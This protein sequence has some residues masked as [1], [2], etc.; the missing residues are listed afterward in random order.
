MKGFEMPMAGSARPLGRFA[1]A[2]FWTVMLALLLGCSEAADP[3]DARFLRRQFPEQAD[4][5]LQG[6]LAFA[7]A[8]DGFE[9][10]QPLDVR[11]D[12]AGAGGLPFR[13]PRDGDGAVR[14]SLPDGSE[15]QVRELGATGAGEIEEGAVAYARA[16]GTS[17]WT[18]LEDGY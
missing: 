3:L 13:F 4:A 6:P 1:L 8:G 15:A 5:I 14:F 7:P 16:G 18:A 11:L 2:I 9:A 17:F 12:R 10:P